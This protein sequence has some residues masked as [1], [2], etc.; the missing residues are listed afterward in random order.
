M[1]LA[2]ALSCSPL[3]MG[4]V[5]G[6]LVGD[7]GDLG[8]SSARAL[9]NMISTLARARGGGRGRGGAQSHW[10]VGLGNF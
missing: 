4:L 8:S 2:G 1:I 10:W 3:A 5:E 7:D 6:L 9:S